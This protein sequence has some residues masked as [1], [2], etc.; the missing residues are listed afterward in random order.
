MDMGALC[1]TAMNDQQLEMLSNQSD[2]V[3]NCPK[4]LQLRSQQ[5]QMTSLHAKLAIWYLYHKFNCR[6]S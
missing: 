3:H 1:G 5:G 2:V 4:T 6:P